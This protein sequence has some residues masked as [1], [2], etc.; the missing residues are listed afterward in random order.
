MVICMELIAIG[1]LLGVIFA[2]IFS[3]VSVLYVDTK[4]KR[5]PDDDS[6]M[7]FYVFNRDRT[8]RNNK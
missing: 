5:K 4:H 2:M 7:R 6:D 8:R 1:F 3:A